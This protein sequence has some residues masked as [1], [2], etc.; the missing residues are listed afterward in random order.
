MI[1]NT[2]L[3]VAAVL[4]NFASYWTGK[5]T[6]LSTLYLATTSLDM[7]SLTSLSSFIY[8]LPLTLILLISSIYSSLPF[9]HLDTTLMSHFVYPLILHFY[10]LPFF[11]QVC[12]ACLS[13]KLLPYKTSTVHLKQSLSSLSLLLLLVF[14]LY[15][16]TMNVQVNYLELYRE[17][18]NMLRILWD[19]LEEGMSWVLVPL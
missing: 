3:S 17:E 6:L 9:L 12:S 8:Y 4:I 7:I 2:T 11:S 14:H 18:W 1:A 19:G 15:C 10:S 16:T 13:I 5:K